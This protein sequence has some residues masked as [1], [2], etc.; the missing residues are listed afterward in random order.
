M[1]SLYRDG[2]VS[3]LLNATIIHIYNCNSMTCIATSPT[4]MWAT[5]RSSCQYCR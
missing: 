3:W 5:K 1:A 2:V 4:T